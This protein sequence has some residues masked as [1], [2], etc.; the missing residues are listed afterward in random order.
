MM[1]S[2]RAQARRFIWD[3]I[4]RAKAGRAIL[5]TT[6]SMEEA[7]VL[8]DRIAVMAHGRLAAVGSPL[9]LKALYGTGY[10]LTIV[11]DR[12]PRRTSQALLPAPSNT[13]DNTQIDVVAPVSHALTSTSP[14]APGTVCPLNALQL[15][16]RFCRLCDP[17][18]CL[19]FIL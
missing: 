6:H 2:L 15:I 19:F 16:H 7:D 11:R 12:L 9:H 4:R 3:V 18:A 17:E 8:C 10:S 13:H 1:S 14:S 5:L